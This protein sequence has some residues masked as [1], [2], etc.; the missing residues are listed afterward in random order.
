LII[1]LYE[2]VTEW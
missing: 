1:M 2:G